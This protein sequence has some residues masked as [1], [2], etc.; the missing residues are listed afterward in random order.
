MSIQIEVPI[1]LT[2]RTIFETL[3]YQNG[4]RVAPDSAPTVG[5]TFVNGAAVALTATIAQLQTSVPANITGAYQVSFATG[6]PNNLVVGDSVW[7]EVLA[8]IGGVTTRKV[9]TF[10]I[11]PANPAVTPVIR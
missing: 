11:V 8:T 3:S 6:A 4:P 5:Q 2:A 1:G 7:V 10:L 9:N